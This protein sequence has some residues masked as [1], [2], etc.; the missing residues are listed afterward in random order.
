MSTLTDTTTDTQ[1]PQTLGE[2]KASGWVYRT[3]KDELRDNLKTRLRRGEPW[4]NGVVGYEESVV[5]QIEHAILSRHNFIL[6]GLR[7]QAKTRIV[8]QLVHLLDEWVPAVADCPLRDDPLN[9]TSPHS[10]AV[11]AEKGDDAP[12]V[13]IHRSERYQEK[14][15]TPD[16]TIADIIGDVDPIKAARERIDLSDPGVIHYGIIPRSNRG[17]FTMNEI[18]DLQP[19]IQV[20]LLNIMEEEDIQIR[21]FPIRIPMDVVLAFTANPEDYTNRGNIITPLK[22]RIDS[23]IITHYPRSVEEAI[24]ITSQ[25]AWVDRGEPITLP[26]FFEEIIEEIAFIARQSDYV[27][28]SSGVSQRLPIRARELVLSAIERRVMLNENEPSIPRLADLASVIPAVTGRVELVYEGEQEGPTI[29]ANK[30]IGRAILKVFQ[31]HY[32]PIYKK[33]SRRKRQNFDDDFVIEGA[34]DMME[35]RGTRERSRSEDNESTP[36]EYREVLSFFSGGGKVELSDRLSHTDYY[37]RLEAVPGLAGLVEHYQ[38]KMPAGRTSP[39]TWS[40]FSS[41]CTRSA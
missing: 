24:R 35:E 4:L 16:V 20:G 33:K 39:F 2:L 25:E 7:G 19:R 38:G 26:R 36:S 11:L 18:P 6:L 9:P 1:R 21:G 8:R 29:V 32:P 41:P 30:L 13:W 3:V 37:K 27:D 10:R 40:G 17:I 12:V 34:E 15:A 23:Q 28:Q 14:L 31:Q 22:D 5:P